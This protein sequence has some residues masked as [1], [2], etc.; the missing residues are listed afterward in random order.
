M[1]RTTRMTASTEQSLTGVA[2]YIG[3]PPPIAAHNKTSALFIAD[4]S[5][6]LAHCR[7]PKPA[8]QGETQKLVDDR[9]ILDT[10]DYL[11]F[12]C[13]PRANRHINVEY[14]FEALCPGQGW[15]CSG[16]LSSFAATELSFPRRAKGSEVK[17]LDREASRD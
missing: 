15:R 12:A 2:L 5:D 10:R 7:R 13:E 11:G 14:P 8:H 16:V 6:Y 4:V 17:S 3:T 9:L 1:R